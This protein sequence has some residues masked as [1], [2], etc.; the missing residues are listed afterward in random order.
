M[1]GRRAFLSGLHHL[2]TYDPVEI[3]VAGKPKEADWKEGGMGVNKQRKTEASSHT[4]TTRTKKKSKRKSLDHNKGN[5]NRL[6]SSDTTIF[7][8]LSLSQ[9]LPLLVT[10]VPWSDG[11]STAG[12][13][14]GLASLRLDGAGGGDPL[15]RCGRGGASGGR[16]RGRRTVRL[17]L[18]VALRV[19][20]VETALER[21]RVGGGG[22]HALGRAAAAGGGRGREAP[23][24]GARGRRGGARRRGAAAVRAVEPA[25]LAG[26]VNVVGGHRLSSPSSRSR[27]LICI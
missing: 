9:S 26:G 10:L 21:V 2:S 11:S 23:A 27:F 18:A 25:L 7:C 16:R 3:G 13:S 19:G 22:A 12:G 5:T 20:A 24:H 15:A 4:E 17:A 1:N 14:S 8:S 6:P